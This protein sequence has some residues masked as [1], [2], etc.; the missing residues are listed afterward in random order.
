MAIL[1]LIDMMSCL[2]NAGTTTFVTANML[3]SL[4]VDVI[5]LAA[6]VVFFIAIF[7]FFINHYG[8]A[9]STRVR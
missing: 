5:R 8:K 9:L 7:D 6:A 4:V 3:A 1:I 2:S